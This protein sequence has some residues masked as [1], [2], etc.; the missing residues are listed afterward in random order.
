MAGETRG[1]GTNR[2]LRG[3]TGWTLT[4]FDLGKSGGPVPGRGRRL[5]EVRSTLPL[6]F[7]RNTEKIID[8]WTLKVP[9]RTRRSLLSQT[10]TKIIVLIIL[11]EDG[12]VMVFFRVSSVLRTCVSRDFGISRRTYDDGH[13][14][15]SRIVQITS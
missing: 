5:P 6:N 8:L 11:S 15:R 1:E 12:L 3:W 13:Y 14:F 7:E 9:S 4:P 2:G 10:C